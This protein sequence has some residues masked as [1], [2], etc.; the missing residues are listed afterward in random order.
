MVRGGAVVERLIQF[1]RAMRAR[2][3]YAIGLDPEPAV[4]D[5]W[6]YA[7]V[8]GQLGG[9]LR[10]RRG[11]DY[12]VTAIQ[13]AAFG[14]SRIER[15]IGSRRFTVTE[16]LIIDPRCRGMTVCSLLMHRAFGVWR[17]FGVEVDLIEADPATLALLTR[18]G[19]RPFRGRAAVTPTGVRVAIALAMRD[20]A[21]LR[22]VDSPLLASCEGT[23]DDTGA[24]WTSIE[25]VFGRSRG[26]YLPLRFDVRTFWAFFSDAVA[27]PYAR[28]T[29]LLDGLGAHDTARV[30][31]QCRS[32]VWA[33]GHT[34]DSAEIRQRKM[35]VVT[36]GLAGRGVPTSPG[37]HWLGLYR[38]GDVIV[39]GV[40]DQRGVWVALQPTTLAAVPCDIVDRLM[41]TEP[42]LARRVHENIDR[43]ESTRR[44]E[45]A[46][47]VAL[48][49][50]GAPIVAR[51]KS[52]S[53]A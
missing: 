9:Y 19:Y 51:R 39:P 1:R 4:N 41:R 25:Q 28:N 48:P 50:A 8:G 21:H 10:F 24:A 14:L 40:D 35:L 20:L 38:R 43:A 11:G 47:R 30:L 46:Q 13:R 33:R 42:D 7:E 29:T 17:R 37:Y 22:S 53:A 27:R 44:R 6:M 26:R 12:G 52:Q 34:V 45:T 18:I 3:G 31:A 15:A 2:A 5:Y 32:V 23:D 49:V 16:E 36:Q